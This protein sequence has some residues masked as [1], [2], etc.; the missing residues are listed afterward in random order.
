MI[1]EAEVLRKQPPLRARAAFALDQLLSC[2]L[3]DS[4]QPQ[5]AE[6]KSYG[7]S[8][9]RIAALYPL[10]LQESIAAFRDSLDDS[11]TRAFLGELLGRR[12]F[13]T[14]VSILPHSLSWT[15]RLEL[16]A[17]GMDDEAKWAGAFATAMHKIDNGWLAYQFAHLLAF[18]NAIATAPSLTPEIY[19]LPGSFPK[20]EH[21]EA[22]WL[23]MEEWVEECEGAVAQLV[24][25]APILAP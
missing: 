23:P 12:Q 2:Y 9:S 3:V 20:P 8:A 24:N 14:A 4:S 1:P 15:T 21:Y 17:V 7:V 5:R 13:E 18:L 25:H 6:L 10:E 19:M 16:A 22:A 11:D